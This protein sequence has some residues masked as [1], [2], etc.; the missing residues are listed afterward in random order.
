M[1]IRDPGTPLGSPA[2]DIQTVYSKSTF[3]LSTLS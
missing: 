2:G 3:S 1:D